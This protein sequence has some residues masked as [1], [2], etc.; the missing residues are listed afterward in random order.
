M[1]A[2]SPGSQLFK[3]QQ[4]KHNRCAQQRYIHLSYF[5]LFEW[6]SLSSIVVNVNSCFCFCSL[7]VADSDGAVAVQPQ[8][9]YHFADSPLCTYC[10]GATQAIGVQ[11]EETLPGST[12]AAER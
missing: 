8:V 3:Q 4:E 2:M 10:N 7:D 9:L 1:P 6:N 5:E 11:G 12:V